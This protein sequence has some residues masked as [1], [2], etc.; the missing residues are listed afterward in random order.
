MRL[1]FFGLEFSVKI[2]VTKKLHFAKMVIKFQLFEMTTIQ[3]NIQ[4]RWNSWRMQCKHGFDKLMN[5]RTAHQSIL[6]N[7]IFNAMVFGKYCICMEPTNEIRWVIRFKVAQIMAIFGSGIFHIPNYEYK[8]NRFNRL[9]LLLLSVPHSPI[10]DE[11]EKWGKSFCLAQL[12]IS[13]N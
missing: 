5:K 11:S 13:R 10:M 2:C 6:D 1:K 12:L 3:R 9:L 8:G 4:F 7:G